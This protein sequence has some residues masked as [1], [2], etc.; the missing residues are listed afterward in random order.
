LTFMEKNNCS[1]ESMG[2]KCH[3]DLYGKKKLF[4]R[5]HGSRVWPLP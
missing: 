4:S 5:K 3:L 2:H 1:Q